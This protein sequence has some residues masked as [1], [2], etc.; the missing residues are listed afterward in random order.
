MNK[1]LLKFGEMTILDVAIIAGLAAIFLAVAVPLVHGAILRRQTAECA[2]KI[3]RVAEAFDIYA[4][5]FG[6]YPQSQKTPRETEA[7]MKVTFSV[8]DIDW[9]ATA[10]ELGGQWSWY[11]NGKTASVVL[12]GTE[13]SE[14]QM[15]KLDRLLDDGNLETGAFQ[16]RGPR[17]HYIISNVL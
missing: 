13:I 14:Y 11:S 2:R 17:Y 1:N 5:A 4:A 7:A 8:F 10:T 6:S 9:W 3:I 12:A 16:R 15:I